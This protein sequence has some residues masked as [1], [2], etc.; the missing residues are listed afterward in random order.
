MEVFFTDGESLEPSSL[1]RANV[2]KSM[3]HKQAR[4]KNKCHVC[5]ILHVWPYNS[6]KRWRKSNNPHEEVGCSLAQFMEGLR[7]VDR[8]C[9]NDMDPARVG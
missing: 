6:P 2:P 1:V 8:P 7:V 4:Q 3:S 9:M 5:A